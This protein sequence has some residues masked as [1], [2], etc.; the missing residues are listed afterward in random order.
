V[1]LGYSCTTPGPSTCRGICGDGLKVAAEACDDFNTSAC[2]TCNATCS[3]AQ[4]ATVATGV[5]TAIGASSLLNGETFTLSD[6]IHAPVTFEFSSLATVG[7]GHVQIQ[8]MAG[9]AASAVANSI[10]T[11]IL[12][13]VSGLAVA[14]TINPS[15]AAQ[16]LI[17]DQNPGVPGNVAITETV[18]NS[19]FMVSGMSGGVGD[20]CP[21]GTGCSQNDDC[22]SRICCLGGGC[23]LHTCLAPTCTDAIQNGS[24]TDV[25]CGGP[26]VGCALGRHCTVTID[27][28]NG[29]C[30]GGTCQ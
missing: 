9:S 28:A 8:R 15:N 2:G 23:P 6:G 26:C 29:A 16:V 3:V 18:S 1:Q 7:A 5:I 22:A 14:A 17:Q 4:P 12:S 25:D 20:D 27:C 30:V 19:G 21:T 11:A 13:G 24:E 10:R